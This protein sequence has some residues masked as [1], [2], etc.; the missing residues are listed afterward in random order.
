MLG[1]AF[2]WPLTVLLASRDRIYIRFHERDQHSAGVRHR[3][4]IV[5]VLRMR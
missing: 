2:D 3:R 1:L 4:P 5:K